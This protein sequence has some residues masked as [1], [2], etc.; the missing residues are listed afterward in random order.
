MTRPDYLYGRGA[1]NSSPDS[2]LGYG[3]LT[4][5]GASKFGAR[6]YFVD[7]TSSRHPAE[8]EAVYRFIATTLPGYFHQTVRQAGLIDSRH[9]PARPLEVR[10]GRTQGGRPG[11]WNPNRRLIAVDLDHPEIQAAND[12]RHVQGIIAFE[13]IN[14]AADHRR[15][16]VD[17]EARQ[18]TFENTAQT[19]LALIGNTRP[20]IRDVTAR[21][22]YLYGRAIEKIE[23]DNLHFHR[24]TMEYAGKADSQANIFRSVP[25]NFN[26][27]HQ[28]QRALGHTQSYEEFYVDSLHPSRQPRTGQTAL[29]SRAASAAS[30]VSERNPARRPSQQESPSGY[31][32]PSGSSK[33]HRKR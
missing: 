12:I 7:F 4:A 22:A 24:Q 6:L 16:A 3:P 26:D 2:A 29:M 28:I 25:A 32:Q 31:F 23:F 13:L 9:E 27:Y 18:G 15:R 17:N 11:E 5:P 20:S 30:G 8:M 21:A 19:D 14:A 10:F 33:Q 1:R